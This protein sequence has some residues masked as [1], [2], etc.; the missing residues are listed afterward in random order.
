VLLRGLR[1]AAPPESSYR[2]GS[3]AALWLL[4]L[5][6]GPTTTCDW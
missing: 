3:D 4:L 2:P 5:N 1:I 6:G